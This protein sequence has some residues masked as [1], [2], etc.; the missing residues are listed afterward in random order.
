MEAGVLQR[1]AAPAPALAPPRRAAP[2]PAS[3]AG[4]GLPRFLGGGGPR[5]DAPVPG[6]GGETGAELVQHASTCSCGGSCARCQAGR[7]LA[8]GREA[9]G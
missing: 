4:A 6:F 5:L 8:A 9:G 2:E 3:G 1:S 7:A